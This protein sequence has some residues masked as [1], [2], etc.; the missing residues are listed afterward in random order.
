M[1]KLKLREGLWDNIKLSMLK[2]GVSRLHDEL[3]GGPGSFKQD[4]TERVQ[5]YS[6]RNEK[7]GI[8]GNIGEL[9][10]KYGLGKKL[11]EYLN[12]NVIGGLRGKLAYT[13]DIV[14]SM[15]DAAEDVAE[16]TDVLTVIPTAGA[17]TAIQ[18]PIYLATQTVYSLLAGILG[19]SSGTYALDRKGT[20]NYIS[21]MA[22]G[23]VGALGNVVPVL[24]SV[25]ELGTNIDDKRARI[26]EAASRK[27]AQWLLGEIAKEKGIDIQETPELEKIVGDSI[28]NKRATWRQTLIDY[29]SRFH[30]KNPIYGADISRTPY[31]TV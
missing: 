24:G 9:A 25:F 17:A 26:A 12:R 31:P 7:L 20:K 30:I 13:L 23:Y 4:L 3:K 10:Q 8:Q 6:L 19:Y 2:S 21:D 14:T 27:T 5:N 1:V 11:D 18:V 29:A 15:K 16:F 28:P 22:K